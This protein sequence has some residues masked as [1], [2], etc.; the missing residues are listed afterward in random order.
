VVVGGLITASVFTFGAAAIAASAVYAG[1]LYS[2]GT[3]L[4]TSSVAVLKLAYKH[5]M[6]IYT[7]NDQAQIKQFLHESAVKVC[8]IVTAALPSERESAP[9]ESERAHTDPESI[10]DIL[11]ELKNIRITHP[12]PLSGAT[13]DFLRTLFQ[14]ISNQPGSDMM[15]DT[16]RRISQIA[17]ELQGPELSHES[18]DFLTDAIAVRDWS[19]VL[20]LPRVLA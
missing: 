13:R 2:T 5:R 8:N 3:A 17:Q 14:E 11:T 12:A 4:A 20:P 9:T 19:Y 18:Q 6:Y 16:K 1:L 10:H 7:G 15:P